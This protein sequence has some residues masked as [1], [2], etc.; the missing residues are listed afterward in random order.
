MSFGHISSVVFFFLHIIFIFQ[1]AHEIIE[2]RYSLGGNSNEYLWHM[3][4]VF[5]VK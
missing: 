5:L 3:F 1:I 4:S 2:G